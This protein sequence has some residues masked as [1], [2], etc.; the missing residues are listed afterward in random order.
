MAIS[1]RLTVEEE[2]LIRE[3]A[4]VHNLSVSELV[5]KSVLEKI[6]DEHDLQLYQEALDEYLVK[7]KSYSLDEVEKE[8]GLK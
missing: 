2:S 4:A 1:V 7:P 3:Y 6:E 8:L 5:R